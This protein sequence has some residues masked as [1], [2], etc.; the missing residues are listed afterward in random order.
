MRGSPRAPHSRSPQTYARI[1][2]FGRRVE[3]L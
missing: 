1:D 3:G 2:G